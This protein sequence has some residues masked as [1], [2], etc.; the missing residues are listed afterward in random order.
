MFSRGLKIEQK[1]FAKSVKKK[2]KTNWIV[3][4]DPWIILKRS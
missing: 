3:Q 4:W 2:L 1:L